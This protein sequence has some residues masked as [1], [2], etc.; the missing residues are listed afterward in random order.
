MATLIPHTVP[1]PDCGD[2]SVCMS[3][4]AKQI[5][6]AD[7]IVRALATLPISNGMRPKTVQLNA[8]I[9]RARECVKPSRGERG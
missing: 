4:N 9:E 6:E 1:C 8:L 7:S 2:L 5:I 3:C